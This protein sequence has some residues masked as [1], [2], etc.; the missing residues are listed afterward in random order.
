MAE[1]DAEQGRRLTLRERFEARTIK[2]RG[3]NACWRYQ[4][5]HVRGIG[6]VRI[7]PSVVWRADAVAWSLFNGA[8]TPDQQLL[9]SCGNGW[10]INPAHLLVARGSR[11]TP[12]THR[13]YSPQRKAELLRFC[14]PTALGPEETARQMHVPLSTL[15]RWQREQRRAALNGHAH[16]GDAAR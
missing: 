12:R 3:K 14:D 2:T 1:E 15:E 7:T 5:S 11:R 10:C 13:T 4:G 9:H 8:W 16:E 6:S